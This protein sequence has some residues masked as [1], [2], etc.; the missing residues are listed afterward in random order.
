ML[1]LQD[2]PDDAIKQY[3][4]EAKRAELQSLF[5]VLTSHTTSLASAY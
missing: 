5:K 4:I 1:N 2:L 3:L